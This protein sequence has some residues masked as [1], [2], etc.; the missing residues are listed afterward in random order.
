MTLEADRQALTSDAE[1]ELFELDARPLGG[2]L[3]RWTPSTRGGGSLFFGGVEYLPWPIQMEGLQRTSQGAPARPRLRIAAEASPIVGIVIAGD[4]L[5]GCQVT[6]R[7]TLAKYLD[8][9]ATPDDTEQWPAEIW[10]VERKSEQTAEAI[11]L[12]LASPLDQEETLLPRRQ[13]LRTCPRPYRVWDAAEGEFVPGPGSFAC[14]Y[15]GSALFD[16]N[17]APTLVPAED[18]CSHRLSGCEA[19][20]GQGVTLPFGGF[21][22]AGSVQ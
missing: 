3:L 6:R 21:P 11:T 14:P 1:V 13:V 19:R 15:T 10:R 2:P 22:G 5:L 20:Y 16:E 18:L 8:D 9:G 17:D 12:E 4:D 7:K